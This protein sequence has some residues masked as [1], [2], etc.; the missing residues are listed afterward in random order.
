MPGY[1]IQ[2]TGY[3]IQDTCHYLD[4]LDY[5]DYLSM[6]DPTMTQHDT[7]LILRA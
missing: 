5:L 7:I 2:D 6:S 1:R 4:Y 3:R